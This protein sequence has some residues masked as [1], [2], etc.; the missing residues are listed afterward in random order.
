[1]HLLCYLVLNIVAELSSFVTGQFLIFKMDPALSQ[2]DARSTGSA[3]CRSINY[4]H[5]LLCLVALW[6]PNEFPR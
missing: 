4:E 1:M 5:H 2:N 6:I 3:V